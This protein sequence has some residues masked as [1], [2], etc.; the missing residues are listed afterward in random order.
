MLIVMR[1][2]DYD[3]IGS[4]LIIRMTTTLH[5]TF[6][7]KLVSKIKEGFADLKQNQAEMRRFIDK[8]SPVN[9]VI[10][11]EDLW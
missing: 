9:G 6:A 8:V 10:H 3:L 5:D 7:A 4:K 2:Y 1:R 11:L